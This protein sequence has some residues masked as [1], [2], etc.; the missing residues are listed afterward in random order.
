[1]G[2]VGEVAGLDDFAAVLVVVVEEEE[3]ALNLTSDF[4]EQRDGQQGAGK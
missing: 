3:E 4:D 1:M 2:E